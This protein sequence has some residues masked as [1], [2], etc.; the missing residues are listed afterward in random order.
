MS[1]NSLP[2]PITRLFDSSIP[3]FPP[4]E[5]I[6]LRR[7]SL[8]VRETD[9]AVNLGAVTAGILAPF[10]WLSGTPSS[11]AAAAVLVAAAARCRARWRTVRVL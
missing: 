5:T 8:V 7:Q 1:P 9:I 2:S 3:P 6:I 11:L 4:P 10:V